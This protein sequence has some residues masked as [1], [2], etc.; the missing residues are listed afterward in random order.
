MSTRQEKVREALDSYSLVLQAAAAGKV[1]RADLVASAM[2]ERTA[3]LAEVE[4]WEA[5]VQRLGDDV[6]EQALRIID[7][8]QKENEAV[9]RAEA[10]EAERD[11]SIAAAM[12]YR[13]ERDDAVGF[14]AAS[15]AWQKRAQAAEAEL[16]RV[17]KEYA[18]WKEAWNKREVACEAAEAEADRLKAALT[19]LRDA[20]E[21]LK[22]SRAKDMYDARLDA[23]SRKAHGD[24]YPEIP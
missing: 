6:A 8:G 16:A 12:E 11:A 7:L 3:A 1:P 15:D 5:E 14:R 22:A 19:E 2:E 17:S 23:L 20:H 10:A 9:A 18:D 21:L 13:A 4:E 24:P